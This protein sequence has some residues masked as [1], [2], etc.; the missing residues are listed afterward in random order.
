MTPHIGC[1]EGEIAK[2]VLMP[3]DPIR[4]KKIAFTYLENP[5]LVSDVRM[6]LAYTGTYEGKE[7]TVMAS[8]MGM[9]SMGIYAYELYK[10]YGVENIIRIG[11]CGSYKEEIKLKDVILAEKSYTLSNFSKQYDNTEVNLMKSSPFINQKIIETAHELQEEIIIGNIHTSD[12]FYNE[13]LDESIKDNYCLAVEM[14]SFALFFIANK[15][16]KQAT[17]LLTVS[18]HLTTNEKLSAKEREECYNKAVLL[19]LKTIKSFK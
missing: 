7:I 9:A 10:E 1:L 3:G 13:I 2:T 14:E 19:A 6:N 17:S 16:R 15:L 12:V 4:A 11:T 5:K 8:G 18:D